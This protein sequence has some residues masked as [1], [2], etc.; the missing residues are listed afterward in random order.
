[1]CIRKRER[2]ISDVPF[3]TEVFSGDIRHGKGMK[4]LYECVWQRERERTRE[5]EREGEE[6][7]RFVSRERERERESRFRGDI[8][9]VT[10]Y[11]FYKTFFLR[12]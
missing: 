12:H 6:K 9:F 2:N 4:S 1:V 8:N 11:Q 7:G 10:W 5:R 3:V